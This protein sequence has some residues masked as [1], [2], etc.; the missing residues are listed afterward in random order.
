MQADNNTLQA[1]TAAVQ[2]LRTAGVESAEYD[3][4]ALFQHILKT[5]RYLWPTQL[6]T[7]QKKQLQ[8][9]IQRRANREPLAHIL[10]KMWFYG[11][12]LS[13][14]PETFCVRPETE[15][16]VETAL[17]WA[18]EKYPQGGQVLDLCTGSGAIALALKANL[19]KWSVTAVELS[20]SAL[21]KAKENAHT[22]QLDVNFQL[23]D[24]TSFN[25]Q[26][27]NQIHLLVTNPP[28]VPP[29]TLP[30]E[31][32]YE[33]QQ[34]FWGG[35]ETGM[36]IPTKLI[37]LGRRYLKPGGLLIMEHDDTQGTATQ[38]AAKAAGY[39]KIRTITDLNGRDRF[40]IATQPQ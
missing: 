9:L 40:L 37:N 27:E 33:P 16:L 8:A 14:G 30:A 20:E 4:N 5:P 21:G 36:E 31:T 39:I 18:G 3:A 1:F 32:Q 11:L 28:Y 26:W 34:A 13:A 6:T 7:S 15:I 35:G 24:A 29:R 22:L 25:P 38:T 12:E 10:G 19:S 23:A 17:S 2:T